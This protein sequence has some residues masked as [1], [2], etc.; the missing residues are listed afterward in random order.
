MYVK[1]AFTNFY[2]VTS[3]AMRQNHIEVGIAVSIKTRGNLLA[4]QCCWRSVNPLI[5]P[6]RYAGQQ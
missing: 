4:M 2:V 3:R 5:S 6:E 1:T